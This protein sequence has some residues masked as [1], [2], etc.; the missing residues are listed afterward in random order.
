MRSV[1]TVIHRPL[2]LKVNI[3][4]HP[5]PVIEPVKFDLIQSAESTES[6]PTATQTQT[7][8]LPPVGAEPVRIQPASA[9]RKERGYGMT[10]DELIEES[11]SDMNLDTEIEVVKTDS[12]EEDEDEEE[13]EIITDGEATGWNDKANFLSSELFRLANMNHPLNSVEYHSEPEIDSDDDHSASDQEYALAHLD[14]TDGT[15]YSD[16]GSLS[17][18]HSHK[19]CQVLEVESIQGEDGDCCENDYSDTEFL[20]DLDMDGFSPMELAQFED[21][22]FL[23]REIDSDPDEDA[24]DVPIDDDEPTV[25]VSEMSQCQPDSVSASAVAV[26]PPSQAVAERPAGRVPSPFPVPAF[27]ISLRSTPDDNFASTGSVSPLPSPE[28]SPDRQPTRYFAKRTKPVRVIADDEEEQAE[29]EAPKPVVARTV[30]PVRGLAD[31]KIP[32]SVFSTYGTIRKPKLN[33]YLGDSEDDE[34]D[35]QASHLPSPENSPER[36]PSPELASEP[37]LKRLKVG[38]AQGRPKVDWTPVVQVLDG[39]SEVEEDEGSVMEGMYDGLDEVDDE[40]QDGLEFDRDALLEQDEL[41]YEGAAED[42]SFL[43]LVMQVDKLVEETKPI[44]LTAGSTG[45]CGGS[46]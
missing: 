10:E 33:K 36:A 32:V 26:P 21:D 27:G 8:E 29:A 45:E 18:F 22:A 24:V 7:T 44:G 46:G 34:L 17:D 39:E 6:T 4:S 35:S 37:E 30:F 19:S 41:T 23:H 16:E 31:R 25:T 15:D 43:E 20:V 42:A 14:H 3:I 12:D 1:A 28:P 9:V 2:R 5:Q 11:G 13:E 40:E 38:G